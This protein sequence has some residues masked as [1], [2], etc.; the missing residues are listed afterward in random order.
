MTSSV[1]IKTASRTF[2]Q[3]AMLIAVAIFSTTLAQDAMLA[4]LP[5][6]NLLKNALHL[7]RGA[8]A[9]FFFLTQLP[10]YFKPLAGI[11]T[12][13]FPVFG[14]RRKAYIVAGA[15]LGAAA[16]MLV[17]ITPQSYRPLLWVIT[18]NSTLIMIASTAVGGVLVEAAHAG[19]GSGRL[20]A[21]RFGVQYG[22]AIIATLGG[23]YLAAVNI[24]WTALASAAGLLVMVPFVLVL[25]REQ[26][27][28]AHP[29][30]IFRDAG[31]RLQSV[32]RAG[33]MWGAGALIGLFYIAPGITTALFYKQQTDLHMHTQAQGVLNM[34]TAVGGIIGAVVYTFACRRWRLKTLL[35]VCLSIA[36]LTTLGYLFYSSVANAMV[37]E[38]MHGFGGAI[39]TMA[40]IDLA[41][42]ATPPGAEGMGYAI[43]IS[44]TQLVRFG[45]DWLGSTMLDQL[46][47]SFA[48][49]VLANAVTTLVTV[50]LALLLPAVLVNAREVEPADAV[51][52]DLG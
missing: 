34:L 21:L 27:V 10:W 8:S 5:L 48:A 9:G 19:S 7:S 35:L 3:A 45:T 37:V 38:A 50:P 36:T 4:R 30:E 33:G 14:S 1:R 46:H 31:R 47:M 13:A 41:T 11:L 16:W 52:A 40:L 49:L 29:R 42:R 26:P 39:A 20:T 18:L 43:F 12:D 22:C 2:A 25:L 28:T 15:V 6:Q 44:I 23:G 17:W 32:A 24:G 51:A